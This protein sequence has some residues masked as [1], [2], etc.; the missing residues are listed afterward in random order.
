MGAST[1]SGLADLVRTGDVNLREA[2]VYHLQN[3]HFPSVPLIMLNPCIQAI[4]N[5][6]AGDWDSNI[7]LPENVTFRGK[8]FVPTSTVIE[9]FHLDF[10]IS[11]NEEAEEEEE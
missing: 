9:C 6:N 5:A 10:F 2:L 3:N 7:L 1:A 8:M 4:E 11:D